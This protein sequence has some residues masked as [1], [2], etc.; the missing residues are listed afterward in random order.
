MIENFNEFKTFGIVYK[1]TAEVVKLHGAKQY[2]RASN[3]AKRFLP[4]L[5]SI[6]I[7][8]EL[9]ILQFNPTFKERLN[10]VIVDEISRNITKRQRSVVRMANSKKLKHFGRKEE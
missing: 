8:A 4:N 10:H 9:E 3:V 1:G 5:E 6:F 7:D 2:F